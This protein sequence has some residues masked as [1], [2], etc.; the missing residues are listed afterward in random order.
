MNVKQNVNNNLDTQVTE[1]GVASELTLG[2]QVG[3]KME[4]FQRNFYMGRSETTTQVTEL[5]SA[6]KLTLGFGG[7]IP[8]TKRTWNIGWSSI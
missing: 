2:N 7:G 1:L 8:E 4:G 5:G 6:T 3:N